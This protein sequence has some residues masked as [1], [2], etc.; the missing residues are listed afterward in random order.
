MVMPLDNRIF[1]N[2]LI[3]LI[4]ELIH[5]FPVHNIR[6]DKP[7]RRF[8]IMI[9]N[10]ISNICTQIHLYPIKITSQ[11]LS[12]IVIEII[13]IDYISKRNIPFVPVCPILQMRECGFKRKS[14]KTQPIKT[15]VHQYFFCFL[16]V[17]NNQTPFF[18]Q[19]D[20]FFYGSS[21]LFHILFC[22]FRKDTNKPSGMPNLSEHSRDG[23]I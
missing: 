23:S 3:Y 9:G 12:Q 6:I 21:F 5:I 8:F 14:I 20:L 17:G 19:S 1:T 22:I 4:L 7:C 13:Q 15:D 10:S 2:R 16:F 18:R 11:N